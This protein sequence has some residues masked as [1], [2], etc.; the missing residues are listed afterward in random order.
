MNGMPVAAN[1]LMLQ[2]ADN[3]IVVAHMPTFTNIATFESAESISL[4]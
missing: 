2:G 4:H 3:F 1:K